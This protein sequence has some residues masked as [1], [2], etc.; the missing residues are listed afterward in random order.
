[1]LPVARYND[2]PSFYEVNIWNFILSFIH[3]FVHR[4][5]FKFLKLLRLL[6]ATATATGV[7]VS[8][9]KPEL[10]SLLNSY[11]LW[12]KYAC[13]YILCYSNNSAAL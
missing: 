3:S 11:L 7:V 2:V 5:Y 9:P 1:M 10:N 12:S 4:N 8:Q 6:L 13:T